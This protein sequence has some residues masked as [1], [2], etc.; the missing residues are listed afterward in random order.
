MRYDMDLATYLRDK[1]NL[2]SYIE[3]DPRVEVGRFD[4]LIWGKER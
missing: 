1:P 2:L 3:S 4:H